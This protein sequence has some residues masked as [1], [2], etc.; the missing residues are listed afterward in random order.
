MNQPSL[1]AKLHFQCI[2]LTPFAL[3]LFLAS[4]FFGCSK[5]QS[6]QET[7]AKPTVTLE[8]LQTAYAKSIKHQMMY[9]QFVAE[10]EKEKLPNIARLYKAVARSEEIHAANHA[11]LMK[12]NGV[13]AQMPTPEKVAVGTT[14]QTLK[15]SVSSEDIEIGSMYS[16][17]IK[18]AVQEKFQAASDQFKLISDSDTR[19]QELLKDAYDR[20]TKI[21]KVPYYVC[22]KCGYIVDNETADECPLC[23]SPKKTFEKF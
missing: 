2:L 9:T 5:E 18:T 14:L 7:V 11:R 19:Q 16:N 20:A 17:L 12:E 23:K 3:V 10:A 8:N 6:K 15:M 1:L 13:E 4:I 21:A 22:P